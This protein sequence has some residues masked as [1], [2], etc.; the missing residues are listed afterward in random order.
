MNDKRLTTALQGMKE[1]TQQFE[2]LIPGTLGI[3]LG[4]QVLVQVPSRPSYVYVQLRDNQ[5]ELVQAYNDQVSA[6]Y[7]LPVLVKWQRNKYIVVGRDSI[8]Y[9]YWGSNNPY[10]PLHGST[11]SFSRNPNEGTDI[12]FIYSQQFM[13]LLAMPS[14]TLNNGSSLIINPYLRLR[15]DGTWSYDGST[16]TINFSAYNPTSGA[17]AV[18]ALVYLDTTLNQFGVLVNSGSYFPNYLTGTSQIAN[19]LPQVTNPNFIPIAAVRLLTGTNLVTWDNL[20]DARQFIQYRITGS[21]GGGGGSP[22]GPAG[23]D[24][25]GTYPNPTVKA[26]QGVPVLVGTPNNGQFLTYITADGQWEFSSLTVGSGILKSGTTDLSV[27][28]ENNLTDIKSDGITSVGVSTQVPRS[29][30]IHSIT[31]TLLLNMPDATMINGRFLPSLTGTGLRL[32]LKGMDGNNPSQFNPVFFRIANVI[33][34]VTGTTFVAVASGTNTFNAGSSEMRTN[35]IDYFIYAGFNA[36]DGLVIGFSRIPF[37]RLFSDFSAVATNEQYIAL[38]TSTHAA[39]TDPY[40][41]LG[42]F[43]ATLNSGTVFGW[44]VPAYTQINLLQQPSFETR[45]SN[46]RPV[47]AGYSAIP[48]N[49]LYQYKVIDELVYLNMRELTN[50]TSNSTGT[51]YTLPFTCLTL[52]NLEFQQSAQMLDNGAF[53]ASTA[54]VQVLSNG[55]TV[56]CFKDYSGAFWTT[57]GGKRMASLS[58]PF[59]YR[60]N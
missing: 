39:G 1:Q 42:R 2:E 8:R 56:N 19:Y 41:N 28:F 47:P 11:H 16:G 21:G 34:I 52:T 43:A 30:H 23:G 10:I 26:I 45:W 15:Q 44:S 32:E 49:V 13:P 17:F 57:S 29:D 9:S 4:G 33:H 3:P 36:T 60:I 25:T 24:L 35:E 18:M 22:T 14:G 59:F 51:T 38:S 20:Y 55:T 48:G 54:L 40:V 7:G 37:G 12:A 5:N 53:L 27:D 58:Q 50:G 6:T 31:G 46:W